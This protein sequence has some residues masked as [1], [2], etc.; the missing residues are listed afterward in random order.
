MILWS[1]DGQG[2]ACLNKFE[3]ISLISVF[4]GILID[5][6]LPRILNDDSRLSSDFVT[7]IYSYLEN[8]RKFGILRIKI[9]LL[10]N[11]GKLKGRGKIFLVEGIFYE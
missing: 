9:F 5:G 11:C 2:A 4:G 8:D 6:G 1:S 7:Y 10:K 3:S